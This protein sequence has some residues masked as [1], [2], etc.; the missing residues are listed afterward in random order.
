MRVARMLTAL[1]LLLTGCS[2]ASS[3]SGADSAAVTA[4]VTTSGA[5]LEIVCFQAGK[6]DAFLFLTPKSAVLIDCGEKG[7]G[8]TILAELEA[9]GI[10]QLDCMI[11]THFDQDHV[12]GAARI[13]NNFPVVRILQSHFS[14]DSEEYKK[15]VKATKNAGIEPETV[16]D[17]LSHGLLCQPSQTDEIR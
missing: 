5:D 3:D 11:I 12:G 15:Y 1:L 4:T 2:V 13:L 10:E 17:N 7:F 14:K 6:A 16:R 9:R 8:K